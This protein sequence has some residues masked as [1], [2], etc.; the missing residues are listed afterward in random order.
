MGAVSRWRGGVG[1]EG[2]CSMGYGI[3]G[4]ARKITFPDVPADV[5]SA[6]FSVGGLEMRPT[7]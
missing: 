1:D 3:L 6:S 4:T 2:I 7:G 5:A